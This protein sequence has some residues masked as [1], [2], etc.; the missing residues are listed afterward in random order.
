MYPK[1]IGSDRDEGREQVDRQVV[2]GCAR[3][4]LRVRVLRRRITTELPDVSR[5]ARL[6]ARKRALRESA[7]RRRFLFVEQ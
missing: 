7:Q 2:V 6:F 5:I 1:Y 3:N 4:R